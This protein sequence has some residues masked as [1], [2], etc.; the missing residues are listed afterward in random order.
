MKDYHVGTDE[1]LTVTHTKNIPG[2]TIIHFQGLHQVEPPAVEDDL[3]S[4]KGLRRMAETVRRVY[5]YAS[6]QNCMRKFM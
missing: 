1:K 5:Q 4:Q 6:F 2:N 3:S